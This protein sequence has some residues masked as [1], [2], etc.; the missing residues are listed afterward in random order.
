MRVDRFSFGSIRIDGKIYENDVVL[1]RGKVRKRKKKAS[2]PFRDRFGHTPLS[3]EENIPWK[4]ATLVV[5]TGAEGS[6]PVELVAVP[7]E[8]AIALL[9]T[10]AKPT[11][12]VLHITC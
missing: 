3:T 7:T 2:K 9:K 5:G 8:K 11:N 1:D 12:A 6:L 10:T 4:C